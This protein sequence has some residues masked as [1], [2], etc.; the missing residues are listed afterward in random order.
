MVVPL[1]SVVGAECMSV[2]RGAEV[3]GSNSAG[4]G[5]SGR[6]PERSVLVESVHKSLSEAI[7][8][9]AKPATNGGFAVAKDTAEKSAIELWRP[10]ER[11]ARTEIFLIPV[12]IA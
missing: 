6:K 2:K 5:K 4:V 1:L 7:V 11:R 10:S 3:H 8:D 9:H 12:V